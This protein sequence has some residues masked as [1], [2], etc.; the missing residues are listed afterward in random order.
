MKKGRR[1]NQ[2]GTE[3]MRKHG[4]GTKAKGRGGRGTKKEETKR[5]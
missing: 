2:D 3:E 4:K 5:K 1:V